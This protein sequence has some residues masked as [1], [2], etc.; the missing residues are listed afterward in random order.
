MLDE[1]FC[2]CRAPR[3]TGNEI[4]RQI[5]TA[6]TMDIDPHPIEQSGVVRAVHLRGKRR[7]LTPRSR[8][9]MGG[10]DVSKTIS[11]EIP[12]DA[13]APVNVLQAPLSVGLNFETKKRFKATIPLGGHILYRKIP[14]ENFPLHLKSQE[15]VKIVSDL[16]GFD[17]DVA[18]LGLV[19]RLIHL[20]DG[21]ESEVGEIFHRPGKPF[22][23]K[24]A[25][26]SDVIFP[27]A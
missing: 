24:G 12:E 27:K 14:R 26:A 22:L 21:D 15:D 11:R 1:G 3:R 9:E 19:H 4:V 20:I 16:V 13:N 5:E 8:D 25:A 10:I 6:G 17:P 23:P 18:Q 7:I 2:G